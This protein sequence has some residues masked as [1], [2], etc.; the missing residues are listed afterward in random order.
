MTYVLELKPEVARSV[1]AQSASQGVTPEEF[2][3]GFIE[4]FTQYKTA[5]PDEVRRI[6]NEI[7]IGRAELFIALAKSEREDEEALMRAN[8]SS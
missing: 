6:A 5:D 7:F 3:T 4:R 2:L 1:E 8:A